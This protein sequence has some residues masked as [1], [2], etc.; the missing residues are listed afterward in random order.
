MLAL[1][2]YKSDG[3]HATPP[4]VPHQG[5][6]NAAP[7][8]AAAGIAT[9]KQIRDTDAIDR[10]NRTTAAIREGMNKALLRRGLPWTAYGRFSEFHVFRGNATVE[11]IHAG[12]VPWQELKGGVATTFQQKIRLALLLGG[13]DICRLAGRPGFVC[14]LGGRRRP[15]T[16]GFRQSARPA[17]G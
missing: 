5:T 7:I 3:A 1:L 17:R 15:D 2:D 11:D 12:R 6:F 10:A 4:R 9:L 14:S 13:V 8:S 16:R